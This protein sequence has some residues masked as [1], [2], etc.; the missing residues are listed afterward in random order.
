MNNEKGGIMKAIF[1]IMLTAAVL[2]IAG[3]GG[4]TD[5]DTASDTTSGGTGKEPTMREALEDAGIAIDPDLRDFMLLEERRA[6]QKYTVSYTSSL[7]GQGENTQTEMIT[8]MTIYH[9]AEDRVRTDTKILD[10]EGNIEGRT[11]T[12]SDRYVTCQKATTWR[13]NEVTLFDVDA[14]VDEG[15]DEEIDAV[16]YDVEDL[17]Y[18]TT[19]NRD[20]QETIVGQ[21]TDCWRLKIK[22]SFTGREC[23]NKKGVMLLTTGIDSTG[24]TIEILATSYTDSVREA[25]LALP[26]EPVKAGSDADQQASC[27]DACK[28]L[29][30]SD[31][32][33]QEMCSSFQ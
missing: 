12:L 33:C 1:M 29:E 21:L 17:Q 3:C 5:Q 27:Y 18:S 13:C 20:G 15:D 28:L 2:L 10:I 14:Q 26:A 6:D 25:D 8:E 23:R 4:S 30:T 19:V 22:N 32:D 31:A 16:A 24:G 7:S 9:A 11:Y